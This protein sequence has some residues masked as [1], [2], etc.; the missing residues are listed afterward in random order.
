M[1]NGTK[2]T[3]HHQAQ[4]TRR[5]ALLDRIN[6]KL[7]VREFSKVMKKLNSWLFL[8]PDALLNLLNFWFSLCPL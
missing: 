4:R 1:G 7:R 5:K 3:V 6:K 2:A 8:R